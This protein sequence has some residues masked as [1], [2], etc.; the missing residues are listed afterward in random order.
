[1]S[2]L[3]ISEAERDFFP[4]QPFILFRPSVDCMR[5]THIGKGNLLYSVYQFKC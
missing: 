4:T 1:M 2:H 3:E 5:P